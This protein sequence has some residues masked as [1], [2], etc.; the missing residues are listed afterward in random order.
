MVKSHS[1]SDIRVFNSLALS[2]LN[3]SLKTCYLSHERE[4]RRIHDRCAEWGSFIEHGFFHLNRSK[5]P[6]WPRSNTSCLQTNCCPV[7][8]QE[9]LAL[10]HSD[11]L[12]GSGCRLGFS[13]LRSTFMLLRWSRLKIST[14]D[15]TSI[16]VAVAEGM[17]SLDNSIWTSLFVFCFFLNFLV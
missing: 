6:W 1:L 10:S 4:K 2:N 8:R 17:A 14:I 15:F 9:T 5:Y 7:V 11:E 16:S 12:G 3:M 13:L